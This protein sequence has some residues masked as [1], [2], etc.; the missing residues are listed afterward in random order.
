MKKWGTKYRQSN[1]RAIFYL[2]CVLCV[3]L[4]R[5]Q[6]FFILFIKFPI[7]QDSLGFY[8]VHFVTAYRIDGT[9]HACTYEYLACVVR[10]VHGKYTQQLSWK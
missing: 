10:A 4:Y 3:C 5:L 9:S 2:A 1:I 8:R 7:P 6:F